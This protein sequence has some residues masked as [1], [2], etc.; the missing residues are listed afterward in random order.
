MKRRITKWLAVALALVFF[1]T[2]IPTF[3]SDAAT[4]GWKKF[5]S[6]GVSRGWKYQLANAR[7]LKNQLV[8]IN[9]RWYYFNSDGYLNTGG[10]T[11]RWGHM[12]WRG[13]QMEYGTTKNGV[14]KYSKY[15][16]A[17]TIKRVGEWKVDKTG[18]WFQ[19]GNTYYRSGTIYINDGLYTFN[20]KGY[21]VNDKT[22][23]VVKP[24][25]YKIKRI[26]NSFM[27]YEVTSK[28]TVKKTN[29]YLS[30][31]YTVLRK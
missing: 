29:S 1:I 24:G 16:G 26:K 27:K 22:G 2:A 9:G 30:G 18:Y 25:T 15:E 21:L 13:Y 12:Y 4:W 3:E 20:S 28:G 14:T 8:K 5:T 7:Y 6:G 23:K 11:S 10:V 17:I 31:S 19:Y